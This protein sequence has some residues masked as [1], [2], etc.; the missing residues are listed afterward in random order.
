VS[1]RVEKLVAKLKKFY[2][3][4]PAPPSDAFTLF[5]WQI[6]WN[7]TT[8]K[9]RDAAMAAL[10]KIGALTPD[11]M[12]NA[13][14]KALLD[15]VNKAGP[16]GEQRLMGLRKGVE[17][18]RREPDL[19]DALKDDQRTA[20]R[21]M[22]PLPRMSGDGPAYRM[23]LFAGD[24]AVLP[25]DARFA[26]VATR[27]GYGEKKDDFSKVA[28]SVRQAMTPELGT[29]LKACRDTYLYFEHHGTGTCT[30]TSPHCDDC[31]LVDDCPSRQA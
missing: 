14:P 7:H 16:Y 18:F 22:K 2:G 19:T 29:S 8:A 6:L 12:W 25:V 5:V 4:L 17:V 20:L 28:R 21:R 10:K 23:L 31:P 24:H 9:K 27:L 26:R 11:G 30:E 13:S 3:A 15:A 1:T